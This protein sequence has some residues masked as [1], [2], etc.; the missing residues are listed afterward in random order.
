[1]DKK[2]SGLSSSGL[3]MRESFWPEIS[4]RVD[5]TRMVEQLR[6]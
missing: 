3:F 1:V 6:R 4:I 2:D 5:D